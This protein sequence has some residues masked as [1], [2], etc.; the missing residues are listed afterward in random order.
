[1]GP[2][3]DHNSAVA[4]SSSACIPVAETA[5]SRGKSGRARSTSIVSRNVF[6]VLAELNW[7]IYPIPF[8]VV[9]KA[10]LQRWIDGLGPRNPLRLARK[11][12]VRVLRVFGPVQCGMGTKNPSF[13][14]CDQTFFTT[15]A[16]RATIL[17]S[18]STMNLPWRTCHLPSV[19]TF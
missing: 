8:A 12:A 11:A 17:D 5:K 10:L 7:M 19:I 1:M 18:S 14:S 9:Q 13:S 3:H 15:A 6:T 16:P 4:G 2:S